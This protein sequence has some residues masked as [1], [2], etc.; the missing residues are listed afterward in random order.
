MTIPQILREFHDRFM[1]NERFYSVI[2]TAVNVDETKR[3]C[4][5][6]PLEDDAIRTGVRLQS[7][8]SETQGFVLIPKEGSFIAVTF[9]DKSK[10]FV[11]LTSELEKII[12]DTDLV[13][14]NGGNNGGLIN[15]EGLVDRMNEIETKLNG[16]VDD[17]N[18]HIHITTATVGATPTPG[19][20]AS[21]SP[22]STNKVVPETQRSDFEDNKIKH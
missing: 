16:F 2:G 18:S 15:I 10:G 4:N 8:I 22:S 7:V 1:G 17:F 14:F 13:Q 21:P 12:I 6:E 3:T 19:I 5:L 9:F 20:L 11:S